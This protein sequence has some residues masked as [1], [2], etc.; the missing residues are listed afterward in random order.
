LAKFEHY[1]DGVGVAGEVDK[2]LEFVYVG[3]YILFAVVVLIGFES[4]EHR[5]CLIL[6]VEHRR[7]FLSEIVP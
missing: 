2:V 4:H 5:G 7:K 3:L 1:C 6:W